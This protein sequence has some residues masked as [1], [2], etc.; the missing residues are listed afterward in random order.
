MKIHINENQLIKLTESLENL[1]SPL[2]HYTFLEFLLGMLESGKFETSFYDTDYY[3]AER[4]KN[5]WL[6][7]SG[8]RNRSYISFTRDK[9][10]NVN[11][12]KVYGRNQKYLGPQV[13]ITFSPN[14]FKSI[15]NATLQPYYFDSYPDQKEEKLFFNKRTESIPFDT[16]YVEK[17][18]LLFQTV[19]KRDVEMLKHLF[20]FP[21][22]IN[23]TFVYYCK[24][25]T[26]QFSIDRVKDETLKK[27]NYVLY[28]KFL[29]GDENYATPLIYLKNVLH[30]FDDDELN[31]YNVPSK[32]DFY[33]NG[34]VKD[35]NEKW[36]LEMKRKKITD[37]IIKLYNEVSPEAKKEIR[38]EY[39]KVKDKLSEP[40]EY[41]AGGMYRD[42]PVRTYYDDT[43]YLKDFLSF[44][45][46]IWYEENETKEGNNLLTYN[47]LFGNGHKYD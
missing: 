38:K 13:R 12:D 46:E 37:E 28:S 33:Y 4:S 29:N 26:S 40:Y 25:A 36:E 7:I 30:Y 31:N 5:G 45:N 27:D 41:K 14:F 35:E 9:R 10:Y 6:R 15:R 42:E 34:H 20:D 8:E 44:V 22:I 47:N 1:D 39:N 2:Y 17:I 21:E 16:R 43:K 11:L 19:Q 18:D 24:Y 3:R 23:K 32:I